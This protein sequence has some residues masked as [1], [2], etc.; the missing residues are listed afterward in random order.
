MRSQNR[1]NYFG[2]IMVS[3]CTL[4]HESIFSNCF[5]LVRVVVELEPIQG[6]LSARRMNSLRIG[7]QGTTH[8]LTS[9]THTHLEEIC[10][11]Q[12]AYLH[13]GRKLENSKGI[14]TD[15]GR[16]YETPSQIV[17]QVQDLP[18]DLGAVRWKRYPLMKRYLKK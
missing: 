15:R 17:T 18:R 4:I 3:I 6:T 9:H 11:S 8:S 12:S 13:S 7:C 5:I 1:Y 16:T 14:H 10:H 2:P